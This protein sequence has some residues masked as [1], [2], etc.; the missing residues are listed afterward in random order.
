MSNMHSNDLI[1]YLDELISQNEDF[2]VEIDAALILEGKTDFKVYDKMLLNSNVSRDKYEIV[3]GGCK[4]KI[5]NFLED[6]VSERIKYVILLDSDHDHHIGE[7]IENNNIIYTHFYDMENYLTIADVVI[8][9]YEDFRGIKTKDVTREE[10]I[11]K[12]KEIAYPSLIAVEYKL[13][14]LRKYGNDKNIFSMNIIKPKDNRLSINIDLNQRIENVK[15]IILKDG[16]KNG[17]S[18]DL[19]LWKETIGFISREIYNLNYIDMDYYIQDRLKG[20]R[21]I[22]LYMEIF[23]KIFPDI[24]KERSK[25]VFTNDLR[26]NFMRSSQANEL[27]Y[28]LDSKL[29]EI[30]T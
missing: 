2:G 12:L 18:F 17:S 24:M 21:V 9:T 4:T 11:E 29:N 8:L 5:K 28:T 10:L 19:D 27:V 13:R 14:Y 22:D 30:I 26:K 3:I 7:I 25:N 20:R 15:N 23:D 16:E 6:K 1:L